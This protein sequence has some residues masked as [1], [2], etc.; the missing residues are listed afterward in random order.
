MT[1]RQMWLE[2]AAYATWMASK[3]SRDIPNKERPTEEEFNRFEYLFRCVRELGEKH[4]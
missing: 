1:K 2:L 4:E 3:Y